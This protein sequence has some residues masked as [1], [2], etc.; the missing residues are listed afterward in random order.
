[1]L[2]A[3]KPHYQKTIEDLEADAARGD[4]AR[5]LVRL[6]EVVRHGW[7]GATAAP[8]RALQ[9]ELRA[10]ELGHA[11]AACA[12]GDAFLRGRGAP[13]DPD[14]AR[15]WYV[16]AAALGSPDAMANLLDGLK[17]DDPARRAESQGWL[18]KA[19]LLQQ[20]YA[21]HLASGG[22]AGSLRDLA[23]QPLDEIARLAAQ[24]PDEL[25]GTF[26]VAAE[27]AQLNQLLGEMMVRLEATWPDVSASVEVDGEPVDVPGPRPHEALDGD[28]FELTLYPPRRHVQ[29]CFYRDDDGWELV[30][31]SFAPHPTSSERE[32]I[33][34]ALRDAA[35][36]LGL[37]LEAKGP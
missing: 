25:T 26:L 12:V 30:F 19:A 23:A 27:A 6:A 21:L 15:R 36:A 14:E 31:A 13:Q 10:A 17:S 37:A 33:F 24:Q 11:D 7:R 28:A 2:R 34:G 29:I 16:R 9:L 18:V 35:G 32:A 5:A 20:P 22:A 8:A 3:V 1:M 4:D